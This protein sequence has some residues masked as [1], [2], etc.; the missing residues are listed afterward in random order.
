MYI[1][2]AI[3]GPLPHDRMLQL[4]IMEMPSTD[5]DASQQLLQQ[6]HSNC[7]QLQPS[8]SFPLLEASQHQLLISQ[9]LLLDIM[10]YYDLQEL[11]LLL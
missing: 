1:V 6:Q 7:I 11:P 4:Q 9:K 5:E 8:C 3:A 10:A 2:S